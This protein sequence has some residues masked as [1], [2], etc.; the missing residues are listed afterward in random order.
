M[1]QT[2]IPKEQLMDLIGK[3][4]EFSAMRI[5]I[6]AVGGTAL[7]LLGLKDSTRDIDFNI[8]SE[9][10]YKKIEKLFGQMGFKKIGP[11]KWETDIG[12][13]IDLFQSG[14]IFCVQLPDG[15]QK[16]SKEI[17]NFGR[18]RLLAISPY[19]IIITKL[20]R[21]ESKDFDDIKTILTKEKINLGKLAGR[22]IGAMENSLVPD[23]RENMLLLLKE[24]MKSWDM[25]TDKDAIR[26]VEKW[27]I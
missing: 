10:G 26:R 8:D 17:R 14:Y 7:T 27:E 23:A 22:Y 6:F 15:Y 13:F 5:D 3:L 24:K 11:N 16:M 1:I 18:I 4:N 9:K 21:S 12:F 20:G 19:D 25:K 2:S